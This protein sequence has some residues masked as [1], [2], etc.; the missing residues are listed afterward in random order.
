MIKAPGI[1]LGGRDL[2]NQGY[3]KDKTAGTDPEHL[4]KIDRFLFTEIRV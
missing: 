2:E 1:D 3:F 4:R